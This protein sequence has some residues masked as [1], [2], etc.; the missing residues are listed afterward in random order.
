LGV[1]SR[2]AFDA[3]LARAGHGSAAGWSSR[4]QRDVPLLEADVGRSHI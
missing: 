2:N 1:D 3:K 4:L